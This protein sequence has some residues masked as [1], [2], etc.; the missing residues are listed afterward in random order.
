ME[1]ASFVTADADQ[2][3]RTQEEAA[4]KSNSVPTNKGIV[5]FALQELF[6]LVRWEVFKCHA[7]SCHAVYCPSIIPSVSSCHSACSR[8]HGSTI[9]SCSCFAIQQYQSLNNSPSTQ[10]V[11]SPAA[12]YGSLAGINFP[13]YS[14]STS[15]SLP[16]LSEKVIKA[17][18]NKEYIDLANL[19]PKASMMQLPLNFT[20]ILIYVPLILGQ[21]R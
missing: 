9:C 12:A 21:I 16:S 20:C 10:P 5:G 3:H 13:I 19:L 11:P 15:V 18:K 2:E 17:L 1:D 4:Q 6:T 7:A 14:Q 8:S